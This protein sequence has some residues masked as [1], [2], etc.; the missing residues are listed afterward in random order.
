MAAAGVGGATVEKAPG[1]QAE[2]WAKVRSEQ[3]MER[4]AFLSQAALRGEESR[5]RGRSGD[6]TRELL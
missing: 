6:P 1:V 2:I 3:A 5:P 4:Q